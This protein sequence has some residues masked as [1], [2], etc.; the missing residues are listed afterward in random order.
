MF[1]P[2]PY[3][4]SLPLRRLD[5]FG[6]GYLPMSLRTQG[7][8]AL[9]P[10]SRFEREGPTRARCLSLAWGSLAVW[11]DSPSTKTIGTKLSVH[12][13]AVLLDEMERG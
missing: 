1:A 9:P 10:G 11:K 2:I 3:A 12:L 13:S 5:Q 4:L 7:E 6:I 8:E